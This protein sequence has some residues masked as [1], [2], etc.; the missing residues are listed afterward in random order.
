MLQICQVSRSFDFLVLKKFLKKIFTIYRLGGHLG[1]VTWTIHM[2]V[3]QLTFVRLN[4]KF[5]FDLPS[6][7]GDV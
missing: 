2:C 7:F 5:G 6:S 1:H 4:I 3:Y